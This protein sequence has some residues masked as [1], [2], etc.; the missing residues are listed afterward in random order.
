MIISMTLTTRLLRFIPGSII[1]DIYYSRFSRYLLPIYDYLTKHENLKTYKVL[2]NVLMEIDL[3]K[4]AERAIPFGAF[5]PSVTK[6]FLDCI[7]K[8]DVVFDV[9]AW[10]GYYTLLA[11]QKVGSDGKVIAVEPHEKNFERLE[12]NIE[13][14][15]FSNVVV[16]NLAVGE[17]SSS[18]TMLGR[19]GSSTMNQIFK[20]GNAPPE[21]ENVVLRATPMKL[22]IETIDNVISNLRIREVNLLLLDVEGYEFFA[23]RGSRTSLLGGIIKGLIC[24]IHPLMLHQYGVCETDVMD[25]LQTAGYDVRLLDTPLK[26]KTIPY[27]IYAKMKQ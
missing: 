22:K 12:T 20:D 4:K 8:G 15:K 2:E 3:S 1:E 11:A 5:E 17:E 24:E 13:I 21:D 26:D 18:G 14:N 27:H 6:K 23:L 16:L 7:K 10:I 19:K 25:I 9:G